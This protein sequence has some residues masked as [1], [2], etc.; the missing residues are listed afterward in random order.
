[1]IYLWATLLTL[2]NLIWLCLNLLALPGNWLML[3]TTMLLA[4]W[5]WD[6]AKPA[7]DQMFSL[8][9]LAAIVVL[10]TVGEV[11][12]FFAG[13]AGV[14]KAGGSGWGSAGALL[15]GIAGAV[16][17][18]LL[19][20]MPVLG[21]LIGACAG[22][23]LG[24]WGMELLRGR[25]MRPSIRAGVGGGVGRLAGTVLKFSLGVLIWIIAAAAAFWP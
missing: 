15:G 24:A 13:L 16:A 2:V 3:A 19:I 1:V 9:T 6:P 12:E 22:A 10:A 7:G 21:S 4:W 14:K 23:C 17:G 8:P 25:K 5:Q 18:T 20:P 11:V